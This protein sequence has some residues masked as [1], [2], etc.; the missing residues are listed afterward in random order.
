MEQVIAMSRAYLI[1]QTGLDRDVDM[2]KALAASPGAKAMTN[3]T[4]QAAYNSL[5]SIRTELRQAKAVFLGCDK[6]NK[7]GISHSAKGLSY[8]DFAS[9]RV[10]S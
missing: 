4:I 7:K 10:K 1:V 3:S 2:E 6:G 8:F 9:N 5:L